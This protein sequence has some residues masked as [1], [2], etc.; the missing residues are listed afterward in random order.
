MIFNKNGQGTAE[1]AQIATWTSDHNY[2]HIAKALLLA[3]RK[4][5]KI[6]GKEIYQTALNH[7]NS[8]EFQVESPS[9]EQ[10]KLDKLVLWFQTVF[11]NFAYSKNLYKDTVIWNNSGINVT[12]SDEYRPAQK[13]TLKKV[14]DSLEHDGY[15]YLDLLIEFLNDN[16]TQF[17][18][19]Q[20][21]IKG[22]NL[23]ELF[24]NDAD[25]FNFYYNINNSVSYFFEILDMVRRVQRTSI[26][27]ATGIDLYNETIKYQLN[28]IDIEASDIIVVYVED[29]PASQPDGTIGLVS[30][31]NSYYK[32]TGGTWNLF[33]YDCR[34]LLILIKS[35]LV[36]LVIYNKFL[37]DISNLKNDL[38]KQIELLRANAN[39]LFAKAQ[40]GLAKIT[41]YVQ[42]LENVDNET[43]TADDSN[44]D[45]DIITTNN[46]F[47]M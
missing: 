5:L 12:W 13:E 18:E 7:Y 28:R 32:S 35:T 34:E 23:N 33:V 3:K 45:N 2:Q 10:A 19:F 40:T 47:F 24:I 46:S 26:S 1:V 16:K 11:V 27:D 9:S 30:S 41:F 36:D 17:S 42:E 29:L 6:T 8:T 21:S 37:S 43:E 44:I 15:E 31:D 4:V 20:T 39:D 22:K 38:S 14:S 25:E